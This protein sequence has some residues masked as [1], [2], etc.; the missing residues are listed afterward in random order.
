MAQDKERPLIRYSQKWSHFMKWLGRWVFLA[1]II[2]LIT[3]LYRNPTGVG[4]FVGLLSI[5]SA[6]INHEQLLVYHDRFSFERLYLF[7]LLKIKSVFYFDDVSEIQIH[8]NHTKANEWIS[9]ILPFNTT[10]ANEV[11][12]KLKSGKVKKIKSFLYKEDLKVFKEKTAI[13]CEKKV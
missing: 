9:S 11:L 3:Q 5:I 4:I 13:A 2:L 12:V 7:D 8:G 10:S 6:I 1:A